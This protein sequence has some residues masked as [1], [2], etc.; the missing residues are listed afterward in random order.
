MLP[1]VL[2]PFA[3][4]HLHC[5]EITNQSQERCLSTV[6]HALERNVHT[7]LLYSKQCC[8]S[9]LLFYSCANGGETTLKEN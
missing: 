3:E 9:L 1:V 4:I 5:L 6:N 7:S 8:S 2:L